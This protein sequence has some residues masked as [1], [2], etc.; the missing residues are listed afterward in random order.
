MQHLPQPCLQRRRSQRATNVYQCEQRVGKYKSVCWL[1]DTH[2]E[3]VQNVW[4]SICKRGHH[5][6]IRADR[7]GTIASVL[8]AQAYACEM[9]PLDLH[10]TQDPDESCPWQ[11]L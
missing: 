7:K 1:F 6:G 4:E 2:H 8:G 3:A 11:G 5:Q 10:S 9:R